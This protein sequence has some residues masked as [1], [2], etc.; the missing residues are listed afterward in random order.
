MKTVIFD[1]CGEPADV[2]AVREVN[3]PGLRAGE[4]LVEMRASPVNPSDLLFIRGEYTALPRFPAVPGFEG[5]G[6]VTQGAGLLGRRLVGTRV[7]VIGGDEGH[8]REQS[9]A[10]A[11]QVIPLPRLLSDEQAAMFFVNPATALTIIRSVLRVPKGAW[12][13]QSAA[14]SALGRMV[15]RMG[16]YFG[17]RTLNL[18][19]R[20]ELADELYALGADAVVTFDAEKQAAEELPRQLTKAT[21]RGEASFAMDCV[22]GKTGTAM[23]GCLSPRGHLVV[24]GT[25][26]HEPILL[27]SRQL[28]RTGAR[29]SG[30]W[31]SQAMKETGLLGKLRLVREIVKLMRL[32]V[33]TSDVSE[34]FPLARVVEAVQAA[35]QPGRGGKVLL[36]MGAMR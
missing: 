22:G 14:N 21:G 34:Q 28:M 4:V 2:L 7:S 18:V 33:L 36:R 25:L 17:F 12:V 10:K 23:I 1:Q 13:M 11:R 5:V 32:G 27:P 26:S 19:R 20:D 6:V 9:V 3:S 30:F 24:Y 16:K 31:L 15:I 35:E 8:W 29:I